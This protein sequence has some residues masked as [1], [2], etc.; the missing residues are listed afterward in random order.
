MRTRKEKKLDGFRRFER[1]F[2][3]FGCYRSRWL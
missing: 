1:N 3:A 2:S